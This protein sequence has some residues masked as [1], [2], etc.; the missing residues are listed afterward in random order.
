MLSP[1]KKL[2]SQIWVISELLPFVMIGQYIPVA[3]IVYI[4]LI[5]FDRIECLI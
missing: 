2:L 4:T 5:I 3:I 1:V